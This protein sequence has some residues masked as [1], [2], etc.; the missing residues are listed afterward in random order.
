MRIIHTGVTITPA[1]VTDVPGR[2]SGFVRTWRHLFLGL[3]LAL[4]LSAASGSVL[5]ATILRWF[6]M[7]TIPEEAEVPRV[8]SLRDDIESRLRSV[9]KDAEKHL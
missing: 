5:I 2:P 3:V 9:L 8:I 6:G 4:P 7:L 1:A